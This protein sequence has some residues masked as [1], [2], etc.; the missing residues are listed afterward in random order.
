[1]QATRPSSL[2]SAMA[3]S[4]LALA[5]L[6]LWD[7]S[8][9][10]AALARL[11]GT[12]AGFP[13]RSAPVLAVWMHDGGK[14]LGWALVA[15]LLL[16]VRWPVGALRRLP[17]A[18]RWQLALGPVLA[19]AAVTLLKQHSQTSCPWDLQ[20]FGGSAAWV[21]HWQWGVGDGGPGHC[22]PA[23]HA[24]TAFCF[25]GGWFVLRDAAPRAAWAWLGAAAAA[26][27][28][29]GLGQQ[30]RGAHFMSHTL[31]SAWICW[32]VGL[33]LEGLARA[34]RGRRA[35]RAAVPSRS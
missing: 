4:L 11:A 10:D 21:S 20:A 1:M 12:P 26:G 24:S 6:L 16:A 23:G 28:V 35:C 27:L 17:R 19:V 8:G 31:W 14:A 3:I 2:K 15:A 32:M 33:G 22:F 30:W 7:A 29:L 34:S 25:L 13:W 18:Q 5:A 9:A